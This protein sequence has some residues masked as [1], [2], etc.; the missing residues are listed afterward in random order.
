MSYPKNLGQRIQ[1]ITNYSTNSVKLNPDNSATSLTGITSGS[2]LQFTLP[3]NS[4]VDLSSFSVY[5]DFST[6]SAGGVL[7]TAAR[8]HYL[9][10]NANNLIQR[11]TVE[12]GG[13]VLND[14]QDYNRIQQIFSDMQ[15]GIEGSSKKLLSNS[16][17]LDKK[18]RNGLLVGGLRCLSHVNGDA[19]EDLRTD[20]RPICLTQFIGFLG[21]GAGVKYIDTQLTG[22]VKITFDL[23]PASTVLFRAE[24]STTLNGLPASGGVAANNAADPIIVGSVA[25]FGLA[26]VADANAI[27]PSY[28]IANVYATIKK[29]QIDDGVYFASLSTALQAG[30]PFEYKF[31]GFHQT[32]GADCNG[33]TTMR[34]EIMANSV[35]LAL[36][37]FYSSTG[38]LVD[39]IVNAAGLAGNANDIYIHQHPALN[40]KTLSTLG[41]ESSFTTNYFQRKGDA[42]DKTVFFVNGERIPQYDMKNPQVY[43]QSLIDF[44]INDDVSSGIYYGI[45]SYKSWEKNY[46]TATARLS[47]ICNDDSFISG[48]NANGVPMTLSV[49][50]TAVAGAGA[51]LA[52]TPQLFIMTS[53]VMQV[54]AGRQI[55]RV[56]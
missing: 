21:G 47:H 22:A 35:D 18:D 27:A 2:K 39:G 50:T 54:Y 56:R 15:F 41:K 49:E 32:K 19:V 17:P 40:A 36:M 16:D 12:I 37:T 38:H 10:R 13:Q 45:N 53:E 3:P 7:G 9:T 14:I 51:G 28:S 46:W 33:G 6:T 29:C 30:I 8:P 34:Y 23:A 48:F 31:N 11:L 1:Y 25:N 5:A 55:N 24:A 42:I 4:L 52:L 43:N 44:G 20:K 26:G